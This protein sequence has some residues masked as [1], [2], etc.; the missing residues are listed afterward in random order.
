MIERLV[1]ALEQAR[2]DLTA[3]DIAEILW[4][5]LQQWQSAQVP[6]AHLPTSQSETTSPDSP[7]LH[8]QSPPSPPVSPTPPS[9]PPKP[10]MAGVTTKPSPVTKASP[11]A[12]EV[13]NAPLALPDAP[14]L[15][16][17]LEILKAIRPLIRLSPSTEDYYLDIPG[18]VKA[19]AETDIWVPKLE[20]ILEPWLELA[21]VVDATASMVIWQRTILGLR[22]VLAQS[23]VFRNTVRIN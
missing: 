22:R 8:D 4:L 15:R 17:S 19:I 6:P 12:P 21:L 11:T 2:P 23:G 1:A 3:K 14:A 13:P 16:Q 10:R 9:P 18:T 5:T 20:P 7:P